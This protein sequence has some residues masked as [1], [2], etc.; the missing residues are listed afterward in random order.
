MARIEGY[1]DN[2]DAATT[3]LLG[4]SVIVTYDVDA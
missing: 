1:I 3:D 4:V 2:S